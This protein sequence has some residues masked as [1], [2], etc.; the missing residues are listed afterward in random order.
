MHLPERPQ[1]RSESKQDRRRHQQRKCSE[2]HSRWLLKEVEPGHGVSPSHAVIV[3]TFYKHLRQMLT[4][5]LTSKPL[6]SDVSRPNPSQPVPGRLYLSGAGPVSPYRLSES[7]HTE[8]QRPH[9]PDLSPPISE[10]GP[11]GGLASCRNFKYA[12]WGH[13]IS[14]STSGT[15]PK[16]QSS[17][18]YNPVYM[19]NVSISSTD[20]DLDALVAYVSTL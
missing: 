17:I 6:L 1:H 18:V 14:I 2:L 19:F 3:R 11:N 13:T 9:S 15:L 10:G 8:A 5:R 7:R 12:L 4:F 16:D 20:A